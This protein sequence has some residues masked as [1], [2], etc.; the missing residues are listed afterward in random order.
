[1]SPN[2]LVG[3]CGRSR[4]S[5]KV[6]QHGAALTYASAR[7]QDDKDPFEIYCACARFAARGPRFTAILD[8]TYGIF[9]KSQL[10]KHCETTSI[11]SIYKVR[12]ASETW[13]LDLFGAF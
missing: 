12:I 8:E 9:L 11:G 1:M 6:T 3:A 13:C 5:A 10:E 7:L 4:D 2:E